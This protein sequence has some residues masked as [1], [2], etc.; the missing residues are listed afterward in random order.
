MS[1][2][3]Y[4]SSSVPPPGSSR[5][6]ELPSSS[7]H[8]VA[9]LGPS[10]PSPSSETFTNTL[11]DVEERG[12]SSSPSGGQ[13]SLRATPP[14][15][16]RVRADDD[17]SNSSR[18]AS[19]AA[20]TTTRHSPVDQRKALTEKYAV[21]GIQ[22]EPHSGLLW[23]SRCTT[24]RVREMPPRSSRTPGEDVRPRFLSIVGHTEADIRQHCATREHLLLF[25]A[26]HE[27]GL[28]QW[29]PVQLH[30]R[31]VLLDH[32]CIYPA[33]VFGEGRMLM[34][35]TVAGG[36][37]LAEDVC[38]GVKLWPQHKYTAVELVLPVMDSHTRLVPC[39]TTGAPADGEPSASHVESGKLPIPSKRVF[40]EPSALPTHMQRTLLTATALAWSPARTCQSDPSSTDETTQLPPF[41]REERGIRSSRVHQG[42]ARRALEL[43]N[44]CIQGETELRRNRLRTCAVAAAPS[45]KD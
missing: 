13:G 4:S 33:Q 3:S 45:E 19:R 41:Y 31:H 36:M 10:P 40:C 25:E 29:C 20:V 24:Q 8:S 23:C 22:L 14:P 1:Q 30:G 9:T 15:L 16:K 42:S 11:G 7:H 38:G 26:Q 39:T 12:A 37:L 6:A 17:A 2:S 32:H 34:D 21:Q 43:A 28:R 18:G 35:D 27:S 5:S 44:T